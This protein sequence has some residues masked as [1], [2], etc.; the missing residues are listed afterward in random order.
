[1]VVCINPTFCSLT[2]SMSM[3]ADL[4]IETLTEGEGIAASIGKRV[5]V[6]YEAH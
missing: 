3:A 5:S 6:H 2:G 1:M 4:K